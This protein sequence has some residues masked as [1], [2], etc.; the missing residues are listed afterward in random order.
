MSTQS[1]DEAVAWVNNG[2]AWLD[3]RVAERTVAQTTSGHRTTTVIA[4]MPPSS[5]FPA[6]PL[7]PPPPPRVSHRI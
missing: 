2:A 6:P 4:H 1:V 5:G 7:T 3:L